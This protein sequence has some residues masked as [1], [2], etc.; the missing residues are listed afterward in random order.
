M[1]DTAYHRKMKKIDAR[2]LKDEA[3]HERRQQVIRLYKRCGEPAQIAQVTE[4]SDTAVKKIVRLYETSGAAGLKPGRRG[5]RTGDKRSLNEEQ[6]L[7]L[8]RPSQSLPNKALASPRIYNR[9][10]LAA[11][12]DIFFVPFFHC[13][14]IL[15]FS[16]VI[17]SISSELILFIKSFIFSTQL[18]HHC[19]LSRT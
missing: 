16:P 3:L 6:E 7:R 10:S 14:I 12:S 5:Q 19:K 11:G 8:Q 2:T 1:S 18:Q 17:L 15:R 4:L 13:L 9:K